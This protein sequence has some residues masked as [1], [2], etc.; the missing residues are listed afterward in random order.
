ME[1]DIE[2]IANPS[3]QLKIFTKIY[4]ELNVAEFITPIATHPD[5]DIADCNLRLIENP[6]YELYRR[7]HDDVGRPYHWHTRPRINNQEAIQKLL[8]HPGVEMIILSHAGR[9]VG[10]SL[11]E[12]ESNN[13]VEVS[14]FGFLPQLTGQGLGNVFFPMIIQR[15]IDNGHER[16]WLSTRSTNHPKVPKFYERFGFKEFKREEVVDPTHTIETY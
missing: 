2:Q 5:I 15:L 7:W 16:I 12:I 11:T 4:L 3:S 10:Y 1:P 9:D 13:S 14:D 8:N 6:S